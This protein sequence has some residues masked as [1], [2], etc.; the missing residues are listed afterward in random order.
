MSK[1]IPNFVKPFFW[2]YDTTQLDIKKNQKR[3]ITN[4]LNL[5]TKQATDWIFL[6]YNRRGVIDAVTKPLPGE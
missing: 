3:I 2:S 1:K 5:G 6:E 4:V